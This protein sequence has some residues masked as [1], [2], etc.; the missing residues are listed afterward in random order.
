MA[1]LS[2]AAKKRLGTVG[3]ALFHFED[4]EPLCRSAGSLS[5][6]AFGHYPDQQQRLVKLISIR[7]KWPGLGTHL[8]NR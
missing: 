5:D 2:A 6:L 1:S 4:V 8:F 3:H 7:S